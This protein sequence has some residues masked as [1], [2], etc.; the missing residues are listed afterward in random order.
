MKLR[1]LKYAFYTNGNSLF[2]NPNDFSEFHQKC[3]ILMILNT[4][5]NG[6]K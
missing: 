6:Q 1:G 3:E 4:P 5:K 2:A